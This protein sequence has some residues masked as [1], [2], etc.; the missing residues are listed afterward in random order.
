MST[1]AKY[2]RAFWVTFAMAQPGCVEAEDEEK[3]RLYAEAV[4]GEKPETC[5]PLPYPADPRLTP[6]HV[7]PTG[8]R[9]P[10]FCFAPT[11]CAGHTACPQRCSCVE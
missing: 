4:T 1:E 2:F 9:C 10:S 3:A 7:Q 8:G 5:K 11:K 6:A